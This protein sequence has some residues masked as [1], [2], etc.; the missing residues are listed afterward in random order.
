MT[1]YSVKQVSKLAG[2]SVRT[3]HHYDKIGLLKPAERAES[4]YRYYGRNELLRLQQILFFKELGFQ[5]H[6]ITDI[7]SDDEFDLLNALNFQRAELIKKAG[8]LKQLIET[9]DRTIVELKTGKKMKEE[10][11]YAGFAKE[12]TAKMRQ[13]V[14]DR[15][16]ENELMNAEAK[17]GN[18][19]K[20]QW[21]E[22]KHQG[23]QIAMEIAKLIHLNAAD[24]EV[25][26]VVGKHYNWMGNF[27]Q[28]AKDRYLGLADLYVSDERFRAF[29]DKHGTGTAALLSQGMMVFVERHLK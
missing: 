18:M 28:V 21:A 6:Q 15:W 20:E 10:E 4:K 2:V 27:Y 19:S 11:I 5:L 3:L 8:N 26:K 17:I 23:E 13:E 29:Y 9:L 25:Q 16:G 24:E 7:L 22:V 12:E 1:K 14:K